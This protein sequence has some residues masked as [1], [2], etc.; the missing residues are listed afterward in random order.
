M[1]KILNCRNT[2]NFINWRLNNNKGK[3]RPHITHRSI[4]KIKVNCSKILAFNKAMVSFM[5]KR[6]AVS[7]AVPNIP[8]SRSLSAFLP[9]FENCSCNYGKYGSFYSKYKC[10][11]LW[12]CPYFAYSHAKNPVM[13]TGGNIKQA[14]ARNSPGVP[15]RSFPKCIVIFVELGPRIRLVTPRRSV[16]KVLPVYPFSF[17]YDF[18]S[19]IMA[20]CAAGLP[21]AMQPN[22]KN[23]LSTSLSL[24]F[25]VIL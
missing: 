5:P 4:L 18:S 24:P 10:F 13:I 25:S 6:L 12:N 16:K 19:S 23:T 14:P 15:A 1:S 17:I 2:G 20:I 9:K 21:N 3:Y 22:L 7:T 11:H 8:S